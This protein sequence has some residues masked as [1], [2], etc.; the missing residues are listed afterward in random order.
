MDIILMLNFSMMEDLRNFGIKFAYRQLI[1]LI[2]Y[3]A[4]G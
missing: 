4:K 3:S 1:I 2:C